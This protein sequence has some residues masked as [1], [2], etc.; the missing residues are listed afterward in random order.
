[1]NKGVAVLNEFLDSRVIPDI[2]SDNTLTASRQTEVA[3]IQQEPDRAIILQPFV[4]LQVSKLPTKTLFCQKTSP[5]WRGIVH[6]AKRLREFHLGFARA[7]IEVE[8]TATINP[9]IHL[10]HGRFQ[11]PG[12]K[13]TQQQPVQSCVTRHSLQGTPGLGHGT[14]IEDFTGGDEVE[15]HLLPHFA[16]TLDH[17]G[18]TVNTGVHGSTEPMA[19]GLNKA[20]NIF[21]E[22]DDMKFNT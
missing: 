8:Q 12:T 6:K 4:V 9:A 21:D 14:L 22:G 18:M 19:R 11:K 15:A 17:T 20:N 2:P 1:M 7:T 10:W 5:G 13:G 16:C 3:T